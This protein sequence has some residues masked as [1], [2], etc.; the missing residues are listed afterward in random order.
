[1]STFD[2][3]GMQ[4]IADTLLQEFGMAAVLRRAGVADR[5]CVC[6]VYDYR[7]RDAKNQLAN[8]TDRRVLISAATPEVQ[9][10]PP[11]NEQDVLVTFVQQNGQSTSTV[12][13]ILPFAE[14]VKLYSPAG[15]VVVY[16]A[17]VR[18]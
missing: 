17:T 18:R 13:E 6:C 7:P 11:D 9:A 12:N 4:S 10:M 5:P 14:P 3:V 2:Y 8:P 16:E 1:M 15:V